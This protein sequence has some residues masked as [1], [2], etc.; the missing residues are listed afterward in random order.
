MSIIQRVGKLAQALVLGAIVA[1][2]GGGDSS[3]P[4]AM[5]GTIGPAGGTVTSPEGASLSI[6][7]G[8]LAAD[9]AISI[10]RKSTIVPPLP[11]APDVR[12]VGD[13]FDVTPHSTALALPVTVTVPFDPTQVPA[14]ATVRLLKP[15][16]TQTGW[17][18]V[19]G[20]TISGSMITGSITSFADPVAVVGQ[21]PVITQQPTDQV[22]GIGQGATFSVV[23]TG[24]FGPTPLSYAWQSSIDHGATWA[25]IAGATSAS[26]ATAAAAAGDNGTLYRVIVTLQSVA[27]LS[28]ASAS[29]QLTVAAGATTTPMVAAGVH[30]T[31]AL[32]AD[33]TVW[34]WGRNDQAQLGNGS[35]TNSPVPVQTLGLPP[36]SKVAVGHYHSLALAADGSVWQW[37]NT[38]NIPALP[39]QVAM[40]GRF[41]DIADGDSFSVALRDDGTVWAWGSNGTGQLG[42]GNVSNGDPLPAQVVGVNHITAISAGQNHT[43][44]LKDDGTVLTW[45]NV[46]GDGGVAPA[47]TPA[48]VVDEAMNA[49]LTRAVSIR[50]M[51]VWSLV[52]TFDGS[53]NHLYVWGGGYLSIGGQALSYGSQKAQLAPSVYPAES[54]PLDAYAITNGS[55]TS[56]DAFMLSIDVANGNAIIGLGANGHGQLGIGSTVDATTPTTLP[57]LQDVRQVDA[58]RV[59]TATYAVARKGDGTVWAWGDNGTGQLGDGTTANRLLPVQVQGLNLN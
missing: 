17:V 45:G 30:H 47:G 42:R 20:T 1:A 8:A 3:T 16:A 15:D 35:N 2:C 39:A 13:F 11:P 4:P 38:L 40:S 36:I 29:A 23:A 58:T 5:V 28:T 50:A 37:G 41:I 55:G 34:A 46:P 43:L 14:G 56:S 44:A 12:A 10:T 32:K 9:V 24:A 25:T 52:L 33:G 19:A 6:P 22:V 53:L 54:L 7:A 31:L 21:P 48:T 57:G 51:G 18:P 26:Y 27:W 49:A 59:F